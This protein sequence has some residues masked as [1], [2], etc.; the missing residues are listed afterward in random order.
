MV[1]CSIVAEQESEYSSIHGP[2][3]IARAH[4][5]IIEKRPE[6][7]SEVEQF[8]AFFLNVRNEI[9]GAQIVTKGTLNASLVHAREVF[10]PAVAM[11]SA[12][13]VIAHNHPSGN[14]NPSPEDLKVTRDLIAAGK[15]LGI[16]VLDHVIMGKLL[17][18]QHSSFLSLRES[19]LVNFDA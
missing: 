15:V 4:R 2:E 6:Y 11:A 14:H 17:A 9:K 1:R 19:G 8:S 3:E 12:A 7:D 16:K 18:G 5:S 13:I 10:R